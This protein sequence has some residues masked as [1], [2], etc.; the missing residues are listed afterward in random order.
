MNDFAGSL[1][2]GIELL[3]SRSIDRR[4]L[5]GRASGALEWD[6]VD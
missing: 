4:H 2:L 3:H 1:P 6:R 5:L